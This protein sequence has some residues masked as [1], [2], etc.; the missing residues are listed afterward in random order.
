MFSLF[1]REMPAP[2]ATP[3]YPKSDLSWISEA[4]KEDKADLVELAHNLGIAVVH[5]MLTQEMTGMLQFEDERWTI[6]VNQGDSE[7][8]KRFTIAHEIGHY[9]M[10]R[11]LVRNRTGYGVLTDNHKYHQIPQFENHRITSDHEHQATWVAINLLMHEDKIRRMHSEGL[12][13]FQIGNLTGCSPK[14]ISLRLGHL[15]LKP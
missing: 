6:I 2:V 12:S 10:H 8:R 11:D 5:G 15:N 13:I 3:D 14:A 7:T 1:K 4:Q 9:I